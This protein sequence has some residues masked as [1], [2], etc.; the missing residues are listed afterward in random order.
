MKEL[1]KMEFTDIDH[2]ERYRELLKKAQACW[3]ARAQ[4]GMCSPERSNSQIS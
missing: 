1:K 3:P 2:Q 4:P